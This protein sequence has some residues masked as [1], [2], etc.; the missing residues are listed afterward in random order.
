M[1]AAA[2]GFALVTPASR[3]IGFAFAQQL[4]SQ[5]S[6]PVVAT[7][8]K[9]CEEVRAKLLSSKGVPSD[10]EERLRILEVDVKGTQVQSHV[11]FFQRLGHS[12]GC[13][14]TIALPCLAR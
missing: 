10:A 8:R 1:A 13:Y 5:T 14:G 4:L 6:L 2:Y 7:A 11:V 9:N 3:G 12:Q